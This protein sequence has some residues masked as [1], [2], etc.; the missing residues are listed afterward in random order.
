MRTGSYF[1][2]KFCTFSKGKFH[3]EIIV[4]GL[5]LRGVFFFP[6]KKKSPVKISSIYYQ[7]ETEQCCKLLP[8][9]S[10]FGLKYWEVF[11]I[12]ISEKSNNR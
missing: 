9:T 10:R 4:S 5:L 1:N 6:P 3:F 11:S 12:P 2:E 7:V 8:K